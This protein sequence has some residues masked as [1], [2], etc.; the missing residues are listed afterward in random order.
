M[1]RILIGE[2]GKD[3]GSAMQELFALAHYSTQL[4]TN[5]WRILE[6]LGSSQY[7]VIVLNIVLPGIDVMTIVRNYRASGGTTPIILMAGRHCS[8]ELQCGLDAGADGYLVQ[9][10]QLADLA[11]I[12]RSVLRRPEMRNQKLL[13]WGA[14]S[15]DI[16]AGLVSRNNI[17]IHLHPMEFKLLQ[18]FLRHPNQAFSANALSERVWQKQFGQGNDT[19]RT[20]I[21]T[22]RRKID[23][24]GFSSVITTVRGLGY[25]TE[26]QR[27]VAKDRCLALSA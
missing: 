15:M 8:E 17:P 9:P 14:V 23:S 7:D 11:A 2:T 21:R 27:Q 18:F 12:V 6:C 25:K 5:G 3:L 4:E 13:R 26:N 24:E 19:V 22:L 1:S 10:F 16:E 20:H